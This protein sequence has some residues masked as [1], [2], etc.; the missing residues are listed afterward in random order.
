MKLKTLILSSRGYWLASV[1]ECFGLLDMVVVR[2]F[3]GATAAGIYAIANRVTNPI[4]IVTTS[5]LSTVVPA[6][7]LARSPVKQARM[8]RRSRNICSV[9]GALF[10]AASPV[11]AEVAIRILG[12][13]YAQARK[14][15]IGFVI[16]AAL[17]GISQ[18]LVARYLVE[19][20]PGT[21]AIRVGS[22]MPW[23]RCHDHSGHD[24]LDDMALDVPNSDAKCHPCASRYE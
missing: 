12:P 5:I 10:A 6:A 22:G 4:H 16:A 13:E 23:S 24:G 19:G 20:R 15:I 7:S 21:V 11:V 17:S 9:C 3:G 8:L 18:T 1:V 14:L 2:F